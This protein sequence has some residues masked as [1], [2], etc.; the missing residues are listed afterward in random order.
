[1][2]FCFLIFV[3]PPPPKYKE[4]LDTQCIL[5]MQDHLVHDD[6]QKK[7]PKYLLTYKLIHQASNQVCPLT[8]TTEAVSEIKPSNEDISYVMTS[9]KRVSKT[10][11]WPGRG[12]NSPTKMQCA[13]REL[14][15]DASGELTSV[16]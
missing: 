15:R 14:R 7:I 2:F 5:V 3:P 10:I 12:A 16:G 1:M 6:M 9:P 13:K 8:K 11:D 4:Y